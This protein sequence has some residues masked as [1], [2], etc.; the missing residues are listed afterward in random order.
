M[1]EREEGNLSSHPQTAHLKVR[2]VG[3][4]IADGTRLIYKLRSRR[5]ATTGL[6]VI[7]E[8]KHDEDNSEEWWKTLRPALR[9]SPEVAS[10]YNEEEEGGDN[11]EELVY[12]TYAI[13][14]GTAWTALAAILRTY[15]SRRKGNKAIFYGE[16]E[17][18]QVKIT[19]NFTKSEIEELLKV[20][21]PIHKARIGLPASSTDSENQ[22]IDSS[23][24]E[25]EES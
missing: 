14:S 23:S 19:G 6:K 8:E 13:F 25:T 20:Y 2:S 12:W 1:T 24:L 16:D 15:I 9:S 3:I 10:Y 7:L 11:E 17:K 22:V 21:V 4:D 5:P 18:K